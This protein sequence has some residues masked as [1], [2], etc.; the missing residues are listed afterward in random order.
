MSVGGTRELDIWHPANI[1]IKA[2]KTAACGILLR[3]V[4]A[5]LFDI[6]LSPK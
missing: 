1:A 5:L 4:F 2:R 6:F 3:M